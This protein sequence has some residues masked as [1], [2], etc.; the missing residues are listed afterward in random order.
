MTAKSVVQVVILGAFFLGLSGCGQQRWQQSQDVAEEPQGKTPEE[1]EKIVAQR[2]L[3]RWQARM[4]G[5]SRKLYAFMP[6]GYRGT[7]DYA[8]FTRAQAAGALEYTGAEVEKVT[9]D[10]ADSC[11]VRVRVTTLY[12]GAVAAAQGMESPS[13]AH[14]R[15]IRVDGRWWYAD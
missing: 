6:P 15:W 10:S 13:L 9:C 8:A 5:D 4:A 11:A 12:R 2:V 7:H 3:E 1:P 14:E